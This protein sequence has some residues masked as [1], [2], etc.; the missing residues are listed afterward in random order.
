MCYSDAEIEWLYNEETARR[1]PY[2]D[3]PI[4]THPIK[5]RIQGTEKEQLRYISSTN[6]SWD[7]YS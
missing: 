4:N 1:G 2:W 7:G 3:K 6:E 5:R